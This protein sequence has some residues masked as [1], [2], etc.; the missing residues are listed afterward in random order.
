MQF[1]AHL[2]DELYALKIAL[3]PKQLQE[4]V[5]LL[6]ESPGVERS[7]MGPYWNIGPFSI[8]ST[9]GLWRAKKPI[10]EVVWVYHYPGEE[11]KKYYRSLK[12][13]K[14]SCTRRKTRISSSTHCLRFL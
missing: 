10:L 3:I 2:P 14:K 7:K 6:R 5:F 11:V 13:Y 8:Y 12:D 9:A 4:L 1:I